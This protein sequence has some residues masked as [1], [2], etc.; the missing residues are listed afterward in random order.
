MYFPKLDSGYDSSGFWDQWVRMYSTYFV[1]KN[2]NR[3]SCF[4]NGLSQHELPKLDYG[5]EIKFVLIK[6]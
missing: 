6:V 3:A 1:L 5:F 2:T 4:K